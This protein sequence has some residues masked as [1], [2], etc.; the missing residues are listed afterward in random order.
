MYYDGVD[1]PPPSVLREVI[2]HPEPGSWLA[3]P[4]TAAIL[5]WVLVSVALTPVGRAEATIGVYF[6]AAGNDRYLLLPHPPPEMVVQAYVLATGADQTIG[7]VAYRLQVE[8]SLVFINATY[9]QGVQ[10]GDHQQGVQVGFT[11]CANGFGAEPVLISTLTFWKPP[12]VDYAWLR[13]LPYPP[14][15]AILMSDCIGNL[16]TVAG[17]V[18]Y[19]LDPV[20]V[21]ARSWGLIKA[22]Y[23]AP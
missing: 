6:D 21:E 1:P 22:L 9:R 23:G 15:G 4:L 2:M 17:G 11:Q 10:I 18:A 14:A 12:R 8:G 19:I 3:K 7:G 13:V 16:R 20:P 5:T